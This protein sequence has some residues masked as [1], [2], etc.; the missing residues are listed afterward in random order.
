MIGPTWKWCLTPHT[1]NEIR[2]RVLTDYKDICF[3]Y[4]CS[5]SRMTDEF[6]IELA[7]LSLGKAGNSD[8]RP[9]I[10]KDNYEELYP[11]LKAGYLWVHD[12]CV[13]KAVPELFKC[14][15]LMEFGKGL[16]T[17]LEGSKH[18]IT[19]LRS[20]LRDA[21]ASLATAE[22]NLKK[23]SEKKNPNPERMEKLT[24]RRNGQKTKVD[25]LTNNIRS[26]EERAN[27]LEKTIK[28]FDSLMTKKKVTSDFLKDELI[29]AFT[30][31]L[32]NDIFKE[33]KDEDCAC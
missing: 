17:R 22:S 10:T 27:R 29:N 33:G 13:G 11:V 3:N 12:G 25:Q 9:Y 30:D 4:L 31:R 1:E 2:E 14:L 8:I 18:K 28:G 23:E 6:R 26:T 32:P 21:E 15:E 19:K 5:Y 7:V 20:S 16:G 24:E